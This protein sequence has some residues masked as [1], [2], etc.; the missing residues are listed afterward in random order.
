MQL[1]DVD[2]IRREFQLFEEAAGV[3]VPSRKE[4]IAMFVIIGPQAI[5][6]SLAAEAAGR[7]QQHDL[8]SCLAKLIR[9]GHPG[10]TTAYDQR[11]HVPTLL[12]R[13]SQRAL[14]GLRANRGRIGCCA[15]LGSATT[16]TS[17]K[18]V[19]QPRR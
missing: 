1:L 16:E 12:N 17:W 7:F 15:P 6:T 10:Q 2:E 11:F 14:L 18:A 8:R 3:E 5:R 4:M 13:Q 9:G 19:E